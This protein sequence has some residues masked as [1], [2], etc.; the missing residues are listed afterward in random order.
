VSPAEISKI[1]QDKASPTIRSTTLEMIADGLGLSTDS[2]DRRL[3]FEVAWE[4]EQRK[5]LMTSDLA[6]LL[7]AIK[8]SFPDETSKEG[9]APDRAD[10]LQQYYSQ[11]RVLVSMEEVADCTVWMFEEASKLKLDKVGAEEIF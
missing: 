2:P 5:R 7:G 1:E 11:P 9:G 8:A 10:A 3:L 6:Q 4:R